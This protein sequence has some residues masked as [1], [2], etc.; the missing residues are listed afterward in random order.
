VKTHSF[1]SPGSGL[2]RGLSQEASKKA[3]KHT[4]SNASGGCYVQIVGHGIIHGCMNQLSTV[5]EST[6]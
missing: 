6:K 2:Q 5:K 1:I 4:H 3:D